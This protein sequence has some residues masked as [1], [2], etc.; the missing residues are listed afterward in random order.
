LLI[1]KRSVTTTLV[2]TAKKT[3]PFTGYCCDSLELMKDITDDIDV[4]ETWDQR[5]NIP[6][7]AIKGLMRARFFAKP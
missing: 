3:G 7:L 2:P 4:W 6:V 5:L 1:P